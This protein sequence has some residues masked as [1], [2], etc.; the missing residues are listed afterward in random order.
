MGDDG[1]T[2]LLVVIEEKPQGKVVVVGGGDV[3]DVTVCLGIVHD[4]IV[5]FYYFRS[6]ILAVFLGMNPFFNHPDDDGT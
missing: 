5:L 6:V 1:V 4:A 3:A 2:F